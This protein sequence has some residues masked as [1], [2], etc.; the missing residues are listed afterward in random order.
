MSRQL[1]ELS[2]EERKSILVLDQI[3]ADRYRSDKEKQTAKEQKAAILG[4]GVPGQLR[5]N[6]GEVEELKTRVAQLEGKL[7][8]VMLSMNIGGVPVHKPAA[9]GPTPIDPN[10]HIYE[11]MPIGG[12]HLHQYPAPVDVTNSI[13]SGAA[14]LSVPDADP[15]ASVEPPQANTMP[16][17]P[18]PE[19]YYVFPAGIGQGFVIRHPYPDVCDIGPFPDAELAQGTADRMNGL[20]PQPAAVA[21][22]QA[23]QSVPPYSN[24]VLPVAETRGR[25]KNRFSVAG[26]RG[27][28]I[29]QDS[30]NQIQPERYK[31]KRDAEG[32]AKAYNDSMPSQEVVVGASNA[33]GFKDALTREAEAS[34]ALDGETQSLESQVDQMTTAPSPTDDLFGLTPQPQEEERIVSKDRIRRVPVNQAG[35]NPLDIQS[36]AGRVTTPS[37]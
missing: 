22:P 15:P 32:R 37:K 6:N 12:D 17:G 35:G 1:S 20:A 28:W 10:Q 33:L 19:G 3:I 36:A 5:S 4:T 27:D 23:T 11:S 16:G 9:V 13:E 8:F 34:V 18:E 24:A 30:E 14:L 31:L 29:V 2:L 21:P 25:K 26:R 7:E